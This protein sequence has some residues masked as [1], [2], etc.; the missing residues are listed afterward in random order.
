MK[1]IPQPDDFSDLNLDINLCEL[2]LILLKCVLME[3]STFRCLG[4]NSACKFT[5][6]KSVVSSGQSGL[7]HHPLTDHLDVTES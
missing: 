5:L 4:S 2:P 1:F 6:R 3:H 7:F